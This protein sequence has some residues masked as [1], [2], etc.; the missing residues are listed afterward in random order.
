MT[1]NHLS[2]GPHPF[3][4]IDEDLAKPQHDEMMLWL[5]ETMETILNRIIYPDM[6]AEQITIYSEHPAKIH[7]DWQ[8][9]IKSTAGQIVGFI[10]ML[11]RYE[12]NVEPDDDLLKIFFFD[13]RTE[14]PSLGALIRDVNLNK[15][16]LGFD[17]G[18]MY[19]YIL[20][21]PDD[22]HADVLQA[23]EIEFLR[24]GTE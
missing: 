9:P 18:W 16:H 12:R 14:I 17:H 23:Q 21:C 19:S 5:D 10:D 11:V 22:R 13:V 8:Q 15:E 4:L 6:T 1:E 24:Y 20:V 3:Q 2:E 7:K